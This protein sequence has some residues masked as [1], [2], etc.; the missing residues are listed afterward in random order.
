MPFQSDYIKKYY[1]DNVKGT[2]FASTHWSTQDSFTLEEKYDDYI[3]NELGERPVESLTYTDGATQFSIASAVARYAISESEISDAKPDRFNELNQLYHTQ[4]GATPDEVPDYFNT[5]LSHLKDEE[6]RRDYFNNVIKPTYQYYARASNTSL[7]SFGTVRAMAG[8]MSADLVAA[9]AVIAASSV[10]GVGGVV[11]AGTTAVSS[12]FRTLSTAKKL[13]TVKNLE[14]VASVYSKAKTV[15]QSSY[16][17]GSNALTARVLRRGTGMGL[18]GAIE[19]GVAI[20][21]DPR[22]DVTP[23]TFVSGFVGGFVIGNAIDAGVGSYKFIK[24]ENSANG[25][26]ERINNIG[27]KKS[28]KEKEDSNIELDQDGI[29]IEESPSTPTSSKVLVSNDSNIGFVEFTIPSK[30]EADFIGSIY[31]DNTGRL[32]YY[33]DGDIEYEVVDNPTEGTQITEAELIGRINE[34]LSKKLNKVQLADI[35][36]EGKTPYQYYASQAAEGLASNQSRSV[37]LEDGGVRI[38]QFNEADIYKAVS[39]G[40]YSSILKKGEDS[41]YAISKFIKKAGR[42]TTSKFVG[43]YA[44]KSLSFHMDNGIPVHNFTNHLFGDSSNRKSLTY[45]KEQVVRDFDAISSKRHKAIKDISNMSLKDK[46]SPFNDFLKTPAKTTITDPLNRFEG[47]E[48]RL[49]SQ[50]SESFI[51]LTS[52]RTKNSIGFN[53]GDLKKEFY[54][55][56]AESLKINPAN[57]KDYKNSLDEYVDSVFDINDRI[58]FEKHRLDKAVLSESINFQNKRFKKQIDFINSINNANLFNA[59]DNSGLN[60]TNIDELKSVI[61]AISFWER[62]LVDSS[63]KAESLSDQENL[64][65][66][67]FKSTINPLLDESKNKISVNTLKRA[68]SIED[69]QK[70]LSNLQFD[71][72]K[73]SDLKVDD[74]EVSGNL[75][76]L[77]FL[78][79]N[80][81]FAMTRSGQGWTARQNIENVFIKDTDIKFNDANNFFKSYEWNRVQPRMMSD[82]LSD[83]TK[84]GADAN[85]PLSFSQAASSEVSRIISK[86]LSK[87]VNEYRDMLSAKLNDIAPAEGVDPATIPEETFQDVNRLTDVIEN[88]DSF[89]TLLD[90]YDGLSLGHKFEYTK[91]VLDS[92]KLEG[93]HVVKSSFDTLLHSL[94]NM[95]V[96]KVDSEDLRYDPKENKVV[97]D[98]SDLEKKDLVLM[99][100]DWLQISKE[101]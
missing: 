36:R 19:E 101:T 8:A 69:L 93:G 53:R 33:K 32:D 48:T 89:R 61:D 30:N 11:A 18:V 52:N 92:N 40:N 100:F 59:I 26:I 35:A 88:V 21:I 64:F 79:S 85:S 38:T 42:L 45:L 41:S 23:E 20:A 1:N 34:T 24:G 72:K 5:Q 60:Q 4:W 44:F 14:K 2:S 54:N 46:N 80:S 78:L 15:V 49:D 87:Y 68:E 76:S 99:Q 97:L 96:G 65:I 91:G 77:R 86:N 29:D 27:F 70:I 56:L 47:I 95:K 58:P 12:A 22:E 66:N 17:G 90:D 94:A 83:L 82:I 31:L 98:E 10:T 81:E 28:T 74:N 9:K 71:F 50:L 57:L 62:P 63:T 6:Q 67:T 73:A 43:R 3:T 37:S 39:D 84:I 55:S 75:T 7:F 25:I 16:L 51:G 13:Q